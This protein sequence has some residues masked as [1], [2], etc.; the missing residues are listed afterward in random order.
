MTERAGQCNLSG[1]FPCI[2]CKRLGII[3]GM[4]K[5]NLSEAAR[6]LGKAGGSKKTER[7]SQTSAEN[8]ARI[9]ETRKSEGL[10][11][12]HKAKLRLAQQ[13]RRARER[14]EQEGRE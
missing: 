12:E 5:S 9:N 13:A 14:A 3:I 11:E 8:I 7:K 6:M 1:P 2:T 10:T 4:K